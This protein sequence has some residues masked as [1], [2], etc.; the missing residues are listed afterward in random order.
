MRRIFRP[1]VTLVAT[2]AL[3]A[4]CLSDDNQTEIT[5]YSD[6]AIT[7]F[8]L[9]TL[10]RTMVT[11]SSTGEDST[12]ID[13][14]DGSEY[15][16]YIDQL[17][18]QV[19]N[20]DSLPVGTD[21][22]HVLC[23]ATT[24]NG[25]LA[26]WAFKDEAGED[27]L[28]YLNSTDSVDFTEP[29]ELRV[30]SNSGLEYAAYTVKVNV[31]KEDPDSINWQV[32]GTYAPF[33]ALADMKAFAVDGVGLVVMGRSGSET[34]AYTYDG[35]WTE[36]SRLAGSVSGSVV[37]RGDSLYA[38]MPDGSMV[39][40]HDG[41]AWTQ[42]SV[43]G[44]VKPVSLVAAGSGR[45][46][47]VAADGRVV[48]SARSGYGWSV[49]GQPADMSALP[50][51]DLSSAAFALATNSEAERVVLVGNRDRAANPEDTLAV[52][53]N[54]VEEYAE[55]SV[56]HSWMPCNEL[57]G[58]RLPNMAGLS[59]AACGSRLLAIGGKGSGPDSPEAYSCVYVSEDYGLTWYADD[60]FYL[61][62]EFTNGSS[63][64]AAMAVDGDNFIWI[65]CGGTGQVWRGR[66][67]SMGW[68]DPQT[69][70]TE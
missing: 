21:A 63:T 60:V 64:V 50:V 49:D 7:S 23:S 58:H 46:Y 33:T 24:K 29:Q 41:A 14:L 39:R 1:F 53:W 22:A 26:I 30:Y 16:F 20:P 66:L 13:E 6:T 27:S 9:G 31:H 32:M 10:N 67:N 11:T 45:L 47:G 61:P 40:S 52:V 34:V 19:Y 44:D 62:D 43:A 68:D 15:D 17:T 56:T 55:N 54:K 8:S 57:N 25:G 42:E 35:S 12:Y 70:F 37:A 36:A 69:S 18:R 5:Y 65:I 48:S 28:V 38:V 51:A 59:M 4:S 3:A 2:A